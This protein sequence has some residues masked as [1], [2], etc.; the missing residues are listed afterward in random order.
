MKNCVYAVVLSFC[1]AP[2][3]AQSE[4]LTKPAE[5]QATKTTPLININTANSATLAKSIK[6][7][8][9]KRAEAIVHY[10]EAQGAFKSLDELASVPG[11][12][13]NFVK[14]HHD[15]IKNTFTVQ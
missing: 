7:I 3:F 6:G 1:I 13:K 11:I 8:G 4:P 9:E 12:G 14:N 15:D 5:P 10:R 2:A